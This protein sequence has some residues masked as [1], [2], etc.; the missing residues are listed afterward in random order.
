MPIEID[1]FIFMKFSERHGFIKVRDVI[2]IE[3]ID[4]K[5]TNRIWNDILGS[6]FG[7]MDTQD[8]KK[9][10]I[11]EIWADFFVKPTDEIPCFANHEI[12]ID[13]SINE[14]RSWF[15]KEAQWFEKYDIIE[16]ILSR[17]NR[18]YR[19][20]FLEA[21]QTSLELESSGYRIVNGQVLQVTS[22]A[23]IE[24]IEQALIPKFEKDS[25][26][27]H[28]KSALLLLTDRANP[29]YRNSIKES[30][31]AVEAICQRITGESSATLG[32]AL[33]KVKDQHNI[34]GALKSAF[35]KLYGFTSSASGIR[36]AILDGESTIGS[37]EAK[38]MLV[39]CSSFINYIEEKV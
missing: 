39:A 20:N 23:E 9:S 21:V 37:S 11:Y 31:S 35:T 4:N 15:Y 34:H 27:I 32:Q 19:T 16:F 38:F 7:H 18:Y 8:L 1:N 36:H 30:I 10:A 17:D 25:V 5:L 28:L 14:I 33:K 3:S 12:R 29:D 26:A 13:P 24:S 6:F 2:Q 22:I